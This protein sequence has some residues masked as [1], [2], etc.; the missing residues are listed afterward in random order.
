MLYFATS[1]ILDQVLG[2]QS[3]LGSLSGSSRVSSMVYDVMMHV[4]QI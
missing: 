2:N 3:D 1:G 4:A